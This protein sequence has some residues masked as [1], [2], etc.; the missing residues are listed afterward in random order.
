MTKPAYFALYK[1][2]MYKMPLSEFK[3]NLL[4]ISED[5]GH[6]LKVSEKHKGSAIHSLPHDLLTEAEITLYSLPK[7]K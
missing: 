6:I 1:H 4:A 2:D 5:Y 7:S 3:P